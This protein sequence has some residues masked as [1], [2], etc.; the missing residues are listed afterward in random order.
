MG[1]EIEILQI[2]KKI[3]A[4]VKKQMEKTQKDYYLNEQIRAIQKELGGKDEFKQELRSL[5]AK[6]AKLPLPAEARDKALS[7][8]KKLKLMSPMSAEAAVLRNY[9]DWLLCLPWGVHS[10]ENG[11]LAA[12]RAR[13]DADHFGLEK[14]K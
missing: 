4:R 2:E 13:L 14:V 9:V 12:A 10:E 8:I 11:D 3:H 7:E 5:E 6:A 1:A